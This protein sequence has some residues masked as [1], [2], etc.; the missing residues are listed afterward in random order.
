MDADFENVNAFRNK[1]SDL[2]FSVFVVAASKTSSAIDLLEN[3]DFD[4]VISQVYPTT[5]INGMIL[6]ER[7]RKGCFGEK[8]KNIPVIAHT[9]KGYVD[10]KKYLEAGFD[11]YIPSPDNGNKLL[12]AI[13]NLLITELVVAMS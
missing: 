5:I 3:N 13:E 11:V 1:A 8:N 2:S 4:L 10:K 6:V 9:L 7:L 12:K